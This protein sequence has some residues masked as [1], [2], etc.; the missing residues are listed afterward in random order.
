MRTGFSNAMRIGRLNRC[1]RN[2]TRRPRWLL[3]QCPINGRLYT[4]MIVGLLKK[5]ASGVPCLRRSGYAQA[6]RHFFGPSGSQTW[7]SSGRER[8][9]IASTLRAQNNGE[10]LRDLASNSWPSL[11][12]SSGQVW[13]DP[14]KRL[15]AC[16][17]E[18]FRSS[19][20]TTLSGAN[21]PLMFCE[22]S[23]FPHGWSVYDSAIN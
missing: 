8:S 15:R 11:R 13:T 6:G 22:I 14:S 2:G 7:P 19:W 20:W 17:F 12:Q 16:F 10:P 5:A 23:H 4:T 1:D 9:R 21:L 3:K 18:T